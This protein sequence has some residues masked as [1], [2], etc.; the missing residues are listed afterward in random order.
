MDLK[1][2]EKRLL[3][4]AENGVNPTLRAQRPRNFVSKVL[5]FT[6]SLMDVVY[7][8]KVGFF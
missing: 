6:R 1:K 7:L 4:F 5:G 2:I 3:D 8:E